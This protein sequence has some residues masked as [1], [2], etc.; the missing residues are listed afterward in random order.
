LSAPAWCGGGRFT[1][2]APDEGAVSSEVVPTSAAISERPAETQAP[3]SDAFLALLPRLEQHAHIY[4]RDVRCLDTRAD[5]VAETVALAWKLYLS[6]TSRGKDVN[7]F[8]MAFIVVA[9]R[10]VRCGRRLAGGER[11]KDVLSALAH[12]RHGFTVEPL[13]GAAG[14]TGHA[15]GAARLRSLAPRGLDSGTC[16]QAR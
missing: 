1:P 12:R 15:G 10:A 8:A 5:R 16:G 13:P 3:P 6:L 4:F 9:A 14:R 11:S 7:E 2:T